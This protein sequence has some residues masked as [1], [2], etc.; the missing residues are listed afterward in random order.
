M[1]R[2]TSNRAIILGL[3]FLLIFPALKVK[4]Q[5]QFVDSLKGFRLFY[6]KADTLIILLANELDPEVMNEFDPIQVNYFQR[7]EKDLPDQL[8]THIEA[9][10]RKDSNIYLLVDSLDK[11]K[12]KYRGRRENKPILLENVSPAWASFLS[13]AQNIVNH[14]FPD[15]DN[16]LLISGIN[17]LPT[18][19]DINK[20]PYDVS[21]GLDSE[22]NDQ[23]KEPKK[24]IFST[25]NILLAVLLLLILVL[26]FLFLKTSG[27]IKELKND[28]RI[29]RSKI[30]SKFAGFEDRINAIKANNES[31][32]SGIDR[33]MQALKDSFGTVQ[34][35]MAALRKNNQGGVIEEPGLNPPM[36][37][38]PPKKTISYFMPNADQGGFFWDDKKTTYQENGSVFQLE[39]DPQ[40]PNYAS[41]TLLVENEK[42][43]KNAVTNPSYLKPVCQIENIDAGGRNISI[44]KPGQLRL[45]QDKWVIADGNKLV[46][47]FY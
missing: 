14:Y 38:P 27:K 33:Q 20:N 39:V 28:H 42:V 44:I 32:Y 47:K 25:N 45:N 19:R 23:R 31:R 26:F 36:P 1:E 46:I 40:N 5:E 7:I 10:N 13:D 18:F 30:E 2:N 6:E 4:G 37:E 22:S 34:R 16:P 8:K 12:G 3:I 9:Q 15:Q 24:T 29:W 17:D 35:D 21:I 43:V 41:F 11:Q